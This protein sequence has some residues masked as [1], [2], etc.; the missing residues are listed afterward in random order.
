MYLEERV[1]AL[2]KLCK[3][4]SDHILMLEARGNDEI[5][6]PAEFSKRVKVN[7][8]TVYCWIREGKIKILANIGT[9]LRI[10]MSQFYEDDSEELLPLAM[11]EDDSDEKIVKKPQRKK[12]SK[13]K[14]LKRDFEDY[15][16]QK[17]I[18]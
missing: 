1:E 9:A 12:I 6:T 18:V 8:N 4:L 2:E 15:L 16:K 5:L 10:P 14:E 17:N 7:Q 13:S 3:E 11:E